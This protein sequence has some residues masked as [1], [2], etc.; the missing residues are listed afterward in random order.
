MDL[1]LDFLWL[2]VEVGSGGS[3]GS[4]RRSDQPES[5]TALSEHFLRLRTGVVVGA[6][7]VAVDVDRVGHLLVAHCGDDVDGER[8]W[9]GGCRC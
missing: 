2:V 4:F 9:P 3:D 7:F 5:T 1:A 6:A 8:R